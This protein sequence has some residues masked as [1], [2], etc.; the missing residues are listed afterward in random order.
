MCDVYLV[1]RIM[2]WHNFHY[3][4]VVMKWVLQPIVTA[5]TTTKMNIMETDGGVNTTTATEN[6]DVVVA[7][8]V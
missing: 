7:I 2:Q 8:A 1:G 5:M 3:F 6:M 4:D